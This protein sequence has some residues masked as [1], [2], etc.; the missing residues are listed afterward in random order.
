MSDRGGVFITLEG[1]DGA[2][3]STQA[4]LLAERLRDDGRIVVATREPGGSPG[5]ETIRRI[6]VEG[7]P[8]RWSATTEA[9]LFTAARRDHVE[10][11]IRPALAAGAVVICDR[12]VDSTRAYQSAERGVERGVVDALHDLTVALDPDLTLI[13]DLPPEKAALRDATAKRDETRFERLGPDF[14]SRLRAA[15]REIAAR[16]PRRCAIVDADGAPAEVAGR[17]RGAVADRLGF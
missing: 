8:G 10:R 6:L 9:L 4:R 3:K 1:V 7:D 11:T 16:E 14:Q 2:G 13:L 12:Y 17:L 5:A 15:F